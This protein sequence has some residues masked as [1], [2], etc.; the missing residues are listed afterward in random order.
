MPAIGVVL[1]MAANAGM[2]AVGLSDLSFASLF[3]LT[4]A[5][6]AVQRLSR[7]RM[8][9]AFGRLRHHAL[10]ILYP[11][12]VIGVIALVCLA[13]GV[14]DVGAVDWRKAGSDFLATVA[15]SFLLGLLT[16][17]L[18]FR[19]WLFGSLQKAG[20]NE[21][22]TVLWTAVAFSLWHI[23]A[24]VM[25]TQDAVPVAQLPVILT[26]AVVIGAIWGTMRLISGSI[27]VTSV[28]HAV[29]NAAVYVLFGFGTTPGALGVQH[30]ALYGPESGVWGL[31]LNLLTAATLWHWW[32]RRRGTT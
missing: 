18:F 2:D 8:G 26:N 11:V 24:F 5:L 12:V 25:H 30:T 29:W 15:V 23:P 4:L 31:G 13:A 20:V 10:A 6:W 28:S 1:A 17:E 3:P 21:R 19:G 16:E 32:M 27:V 14:V 22:S 9:I 7:Q